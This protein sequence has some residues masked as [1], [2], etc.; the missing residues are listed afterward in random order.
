MSSFLSS[1]GTEI[2]EGVTEGAGITV[3]GQETSGSTAES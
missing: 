2:S 3:G 1:F